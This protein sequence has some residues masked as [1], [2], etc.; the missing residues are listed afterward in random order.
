M[1]GSVYGQ[2]VFFADFDCCIFVFSSFFVPYLRL[3]TFRPFLYIFGNCD[4]FRYWIL[5]FAFVIKVPHLFLHDQ[6]N[7]L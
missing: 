3:L 2:S 5:S 7:R 4:C 1:G 6:P